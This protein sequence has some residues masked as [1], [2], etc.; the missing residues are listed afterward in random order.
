M[1]VGDRIRTIGFNKGLEGI[2]TGIR[3]GI[4]SENHG[5]IEIKVERI[6]EPQNFNW[7]NPGDLEHFSHFGWEK[8]M[9]IVGES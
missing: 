1:K 5:T 4:N 3:E 7:L 9:E 8:D 6:T 2:V